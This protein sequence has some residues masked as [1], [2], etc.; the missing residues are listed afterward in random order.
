MGKKILLIGTGGTISC[1]QTKNGLSPAMTAEELLGALNI[2]AHVETEELFKLDGTNMIPR[3]WE[4]LA[5]H[6]RT[7]YGEFDGFV[8]THG[9]DTMAYGAAALS[10]LIQNSEKPIIFTGSMLDMGKPDSDAADNL[11]D[12]IGY[13]GSENTFGVKV[14]FGGWIYEGTSVSKIDSASL[15]PFSDINGDNTDSLQYWEARSVKDGYVG[16]TKFYDRLS[17]NVFCVKLIPGQSLCVPNGIKALI[18]ESYGTGGVPDYL[19]DNV[20]ALANSGVYI[21]IGTQCAYG[22]TTLEK[23]EVGRRAVNAFPVIETGEYTV[24]YSIARAQW[25]LEY[26]DNFEDFKK[27]FKGENL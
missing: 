10:C 17:D 9:T 20:K 4:Q 11:A 26:S 15:N 8:I 7:R 18:L 2:N 1:L 22:G 25:A 21:I 3:H 5:S 12:A 14:V 23:Y 6:I 16:K 24:E 27:L 19:F 13:A